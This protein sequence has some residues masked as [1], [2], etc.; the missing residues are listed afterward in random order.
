VAIRGSL[1]ERSRVLGIGIIASKATIESTVIR[2]TLANDIGWFGDGI[3]ASCRSE[4][5]SVVSLSS[6]RIESSARAGIS[7]F[8]AQIDLAGTTIQCS[9]FDIEGEPSNGHP[10]IFNDLGGN[11]CGCPEANRAC[12]VLSANL[13]PPP[14]P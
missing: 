8:A 4:H 14:L 6:V 5:P 1:V 10:F 9:A 13:E 2:E 3:H 11:A 7:N 12:E